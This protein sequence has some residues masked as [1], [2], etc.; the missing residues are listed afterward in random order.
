VS[1]LHAATCMQLPVSIERAFDH[2]SKFFVTISTSAMGFAERSSAP[3]ARFRA[4]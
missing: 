4:R 1:L 2:A 3:P